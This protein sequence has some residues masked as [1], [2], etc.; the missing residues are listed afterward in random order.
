MRNK[1]SLDWAMCVPDPAAN[2][3]KMFCSPL[4]SNIAQYTAEVAQAE[5][6]HHDAKYHTGPLIASYQAAAAAAYKDFKVQRIASSP[7]VK[8]ACCILVWSHL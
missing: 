5:E 2:L 8:L 6:Q 4:W 7:V 3:T 1:L